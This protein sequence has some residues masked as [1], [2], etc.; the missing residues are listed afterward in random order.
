M[1]AV[2]PIRRILLDCTRTHATTINTGI[3]RVVRNLA[4]NCRAERV[5]L[6]CL[7]VVAT[8]GGFREVPVAPRPGSWGL[9]PLPAAVSPVADCRRAVVKRL[10]K[11]FVPRSLYRPVAALAARRLGGLR[12]RPDTVAPGAGDVLML[13]EMCRPELLARA[14]RRGAQVGVLIHDVLPVTHPEWFLPATATTFRQWLAAALTWGDFFVTCTETTRDLLPGFFA[15]LR[16]DRDW[17]RVPFRAFRPGCTLDLAAARGPVRPE[18][19][20]AL[21]GAAARPTFLMVGT[22]EPRKNHRTV[23][24]AFERVWRT[25]GRPR[26]CVVGRVGW[27]CD[28]LVARI[29]AHP[30]FGRGLLMWNDLSDAELAYCHRQ[31]RACVF[32]SHAEGFGLPIVEALGYG[33][34]T[35]VS[36]NPIHREV[37]GA[38]CHYFPAADAA[39]LAALVRAFAGD[40]RPTRPA[41]APALPDWRRSCREFVRQ[42]RDAAEVVADQ[43][44]A[45]GGLNAAGQV[46]VDRRDGPVAGGRGPGR[47]P[48]ACSRPSR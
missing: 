9:P 29:K 8:P 33:L 27:M 47:A 28:G 15:E 7:P 42:C 35:L 26:L 30:E 4:R 38:A 48:D 39:A 5:P 23:L 6:A 45:R 40:A 17:D 22:L 34:P 19:A 21:A 2:T 43:T 12:Q 25:G 3:Q 37:G 10:R 16:P 14:K 46:D 20:A 11:M 24:D 44:A 18:V 32:A 41:A 36:D 31:A 1:D 13:L